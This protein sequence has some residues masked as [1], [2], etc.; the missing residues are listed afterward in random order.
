M[1]MQTIFEQKVKQSSEILDW[2]SRIMEL[3]RSLG[4]ILLFAL[5]LD[6]VQAVGATAPA[7]QSVALTWNPSTNSNVTGYNV[8]Y[9]VASNTYTNM[10]HYGNVTNT[11]ISGLAAGVTYYFAATAYDSTGDQSGY[12][13]EAS[14][15]VPTTFPTMQI[16]SAPAGQFILTVTGPVGQ[17]NEVQATQDFKTW[18]VIG[19]VTLGAGGSSDFTDTNAS[20]FSKRFYRTLKTP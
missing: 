8:Y 4:G 3:A 2:P 16:R 9:G 10:T 7:G 6:S 12:S 14:Y 15:A 1:V 17:T 18:T 19:T 5:L 11:T 13:K 20:N